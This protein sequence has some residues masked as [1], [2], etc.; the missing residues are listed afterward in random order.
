MLPRRILNIAKSLIYGR[1]GISPSV[2][3]YLRE[4]GDEPIIQIIISRNV[5][6]SLITGTLKVISPQF[7]EM[8]GNDKLY[9]LKFL[10]KTSRSNLSLEKYEVISI[11]P[12]KM[13]NKCENMNVTISSGLTLN[14]L[15][16]NTRQLMG[17]GK[18]LGYQSDRN[19]CQN[20]ILAILQSNN[21]ANSQN[22]FFTKQSTQE[23]FSTSLRKITN[24]VTDIAAAADIIRQ[25]GKVK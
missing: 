19:N 10:I 5:V 2:D 25:G 14:I 22:I 8:N 6:S 17:N 3:R 18:F 9:H 1:K 21:M 12:Y 23:L 20:F 16:S 11:S 13:D 7:R 4:H 24:T 15:S